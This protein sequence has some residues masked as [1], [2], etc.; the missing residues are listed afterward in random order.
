MSKILFLSRSPIYFSYFESIIDELLRQGQDVTLLFDPT[1]LE[2]SDRAV[3][4]YEQHH[5][6]LTTG[7]FL[8][9][10]DFWRGLLRPSRSL[11]TYANYLSRKGKQSEFYLNRAITFLPKSMQKV[12]M[13]KFIQQIAS[14]PEFQEILRTIETMAP[15]DKAILNW[16]KENR[17]DAVVATPM[18]LLSCSEVEYVKAA[19]Y[20]GIPTLVPVFSW[21]NLTTKGLYHIQPDWLLAWND[22]HAKEAETIHRIPHDRIVVTGSPFFDKWFS[23][24]TLLETRDAFCQKVGLDP[25]KHYIMYMASTKNIA[26]DESWLVRELIDTLRKHPDPNISSIGVLLR[27]HPF[28]REVFNSFEEPQ[29]ALWPR[30]ISFPDDPT[31]RSDFVNSVHHALACVGV[32][33]TGMIDS[34]ILQKPTLSILTE[35]YSKT[36]TEAVHFQY[37]NQC[38]VLETST[39]ILEFISQIANILQGVDLKLQQRNRFITSFVRPHGESVISGT[40]AARA[41]MLA[42]EGKNI[43]QEMPSVISQLRP[44]SV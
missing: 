44:L 43:Y 26:P 30:D 13:W 9:R 27:P 37:L 16:L 34:V 22:T 31:S 41:I 28:N 35:R 14:A 21:D 1:R 3:R 38:D 6:E 10:S 40:V 18:N 23:S 42:A 2:D 19:K 5:P 15:P 12:A 29:V 11:L 32:N 24:K 39:Q 7:S 25:T 20:L 33:T 8:R 36:Q 17:P 4:A